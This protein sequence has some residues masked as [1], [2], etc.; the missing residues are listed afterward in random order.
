VEIHPDTAH[1]PTLRVN[2]VKLAESN[3]PDDWCLHEPEQHRAVAVV[4][5]A[6]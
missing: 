3:E 5:L 4:E 6:S 1:V 2:A